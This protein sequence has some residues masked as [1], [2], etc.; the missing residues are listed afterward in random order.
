MERIDSRRTAAYAITIFCGLLLFAMWAWPVR[1]RAVLG[2]NDFLQLYAGA[3]LVGTPELYD[4]KAH[5][6]IHMEVTEAHTYYP[7][8]YF[9]RL[10][11]YALL[12]R[13]LAKL[14]YHTA[15]AIYQSVSA[16]V[17][18]AFLAIYTRK[19]PE[20]IVV[21]ALSVPLL[22][23][24]TNGQDVAMA[25]ALAGFAFLLIRGGHDFAAGLLLSLCSIKFHLFILVPLVLILHKRWRILQGGLLGGAALWGLSVAAG[26]FDWPRGFLS[27]ASNPGIHLSPERMTTFRNLVFLVSGG[28]NL[29]LEMVLNIAGA[30]LVG[31]LV[32]RIRSLEV[33]FGVA[34][35]GG[36]LVSHHAYSQDLFLLV[37]ASILFAIGGASRA[38][39]G[40]TIVVGLP[41]TCFL[42][43]FAR[44]F[45]TAVPLMILAILLVA[46]FV[47]SRRQPSASTE[48]ISA[49]I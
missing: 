46:L 27:V 29:P 49:L 18:F 7:S 44:P 28:E 16:I 2:E 11:Y 45:S 30:G 13:P 10:P 19:W 1:K 35:A 8:I 43:L 24:F 32:W 20:T 6:R 26:G 4:I 21:A 25:A 12:L 40:T 41:P 22:I 48:R 23:N 17:V 47:D 36:L 14:P 3:R 42:L 34:L 38:L 39:L 31:Y 37:L 9:T 33:A 5:E 15:Y